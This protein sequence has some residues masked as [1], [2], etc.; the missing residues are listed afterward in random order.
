MMSTSL[1]IRTKASEVCN[2]NLSTYI[3][4]FFSLEL[5]TGLEKLAVEVLF[6]GVFSGFVRKSLVNT[7][8]QNP[9]K[10]NAQT[11]SMTLRP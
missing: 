2:F 5:S 1:L 6:G 11:R 3:H 8:I 9:K 7:K 10:S 4:N